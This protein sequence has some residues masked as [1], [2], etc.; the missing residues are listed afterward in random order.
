MEKE[1]LLAHETLFA[2]IIRAFKENKTALFGLIVVVILVVLAIFAPYVTP[3]DPYEIDL[4]NRFS[5]PSLNHWFGTDMFGRDLFTRVI[6]GARISLAI[7]LIPSLIAVSI[8]AILGVVS[9]YIGGRLGYWVMRMADV[10]MAFPSLLLAIVVMYTLG[11]TLFNLFIALSVVG[12]AGAARVVRSQALS[13]R[14]KEFIEVAKAIGVK[15]IKIMARHVFPNCLPSLMVLFT[16]NIP[17]AILS[18]ASLS[19]LGVGAQPPTPSWGL[20]VSNGKEFLF[21]APW[22]AILPGVAIFITVLAFNFIGDGLRD[23]I[24]PYLK[25]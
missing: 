10:V 3:Y 23:A 2:D 22:V 17:D 6:Y 24:D 18:E 7:G 19:F 14:E 4:N 9:G 5:K 11:A 21:S 15:D 25:G 12:W 16:M 1:K 13:I 20:L 8:G